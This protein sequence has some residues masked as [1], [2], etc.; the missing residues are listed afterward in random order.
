MNSVTRMTKLNRRIKP[1]K[2]SKQIR[3]ELDSLH[4]ELKISIAARNKEKAMKSL[5]IT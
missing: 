2:I 5:T 3:S 1:M 4:K